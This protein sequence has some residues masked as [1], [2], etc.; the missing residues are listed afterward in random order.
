MNTVNRLAE[1]I[2]KAKALDF[3]NI[4]N[5]SIEL[6]KKTWLQGVL[7][8]LF[9]LIIMMPLIII[10]FLPLI[11]L[12]IA[13]Q[14]SGYSGSEALSGF[15][16]GMSILYILFIFVGIFVLG[17]V[18]VAL[19]AAFFRI[20]YK[21][22]YN[23][24]VTTSDFFYFVKGK[25]LSKIFVLML[26]SFGIAIL[27]MMLCYLPIFYVMIPLSYFS[28]VYTFNPELSVGEIVKTSF[29]IGNKKWLLTFGTMFVA[30]TLAQLVGLLL[31]GIGFLVTAPF[32]YHP[33][34]LIYK[35]VIGF[36]ETDPIEE[37]GLLPE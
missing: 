5:E 14:E 27:A 30:S 7:L 2:E 22:D 32:V 10:L 31:C 12:I 9:T 21:L 13:Q 11:G 4:L 8:Q 18:S 16:A 28:I 3:G 34:Y 1:K 36:K 37:I 23:E 19:N 20:I 25:H 33:M 6:F 26:A 17:A 35:N 15:F 24:T 29:K